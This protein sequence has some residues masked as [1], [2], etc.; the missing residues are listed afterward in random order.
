MRGVSALPIGAAVLVSVFG[1]IV[2]SSFFFSFSPEVLS[3]M[4]G[5]KTREIK[6]NHNLLD[7]K[8]RELSILAAGS[9]NL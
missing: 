4:T 5:S 6:E 2:S 1:A 3:L 7:K 8:L 9:T